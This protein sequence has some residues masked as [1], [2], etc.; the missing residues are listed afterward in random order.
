MVREGK[1]GG[2]NKKEKREGERKKN[3]A[4]SSEAIWSTLGP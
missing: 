1:E 4:E 2:R 3:K